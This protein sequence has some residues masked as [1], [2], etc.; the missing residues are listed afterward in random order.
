MNLDTRQLLYRQPGYVYSVD[1]HQ[2]DFNQRNMKLGHHTDAIT[3]P[4]DKIDL[5]LT[6]DGVD[7]L[8]LRDT[9]LFAV[10]GYF[11][12]H[13]GDEE[14][15][16]IQEAAKTQRDLKTHHINIIN[17]EEVNGRVKP[18][19]FKDE[20]LFEM[21]EEGHQHHTM[22]LHMPKVDLTDKLVG[23][24]ICGE[25]YWLH[26]DGDI[27]SFVNEHTLRFSFDRWHLY[28]KVYWFK[29]RFG[30][31]H[32]QLTPYMDNRIKTEEVRKV[33]FLK[34]LFKLPQ[35]FLVVIESPKPLEITKEAVSYHQLPKRY[36][37]GK[38]HYAP[39]RS[40]DGRYLPYIPMDD[41]NGFVLVT[42]ENRIYPQQ[43]DTLIRDE[44]PY[45]NELAVSN[46]KADY[47]L[48]HFINIKVKE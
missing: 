37:A 46:R 48:A 19:R 5:H 21:G 38:H 13:D 7:Y 26:H 8:H 18:Y 27:V 16:Y 6:K 14:G 25:L 12:W 15:V 4:A 36:F 1:A 20:N 30:N 33:E 24:V 17:F 39:L 23:V 45:L 2:W 9:S 47:Q 44:Q 32:L 43:N 10:G 42:E 31:R 34:R 40:S 3:H 29:K 11:H 22:L 35:S 28:E 41:R